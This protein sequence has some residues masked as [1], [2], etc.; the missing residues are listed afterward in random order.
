MKDGIQ[1]WRDHHGVAHVEAAI[2]P[3]LY[4]GQ[5]FVHA[6]DRG[7]Q[8][9]LMRILGQGRALRHCSIPVTTPWRLTA[10]FGE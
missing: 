1:I 3:D 9:L 4:W 10:S 7:L 2:E 8:I 5:G 6:T